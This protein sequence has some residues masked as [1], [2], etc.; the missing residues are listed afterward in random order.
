M[1]LEITPLTKEQ[2][3]E[4]KQLRSQNPEYYAQLSDFF[5]SN[6]KAYREHNIYGIGSY[7]SNDVWQL[8]RYFE[9]QLMKKNCTPV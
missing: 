5:K 3:N 6:V 4:W 7:F 1:S 9:Y 8:A 2:L